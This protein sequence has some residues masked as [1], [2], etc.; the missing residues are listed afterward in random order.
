MSSPT[1]ISALAE[2]LA[3]HADHCFGLM[4]NGNAHLIEHLS[5]RG[6]PYTAMRHEAGTVAA[7][8][9]YHRVSGKLAIAT[10][11]YGAGFSNTATALAEAA[12]ARIPVLVVVGEAPSSGVRPWDIDQEMFAAALGVR[13]YTLAPGG[14]A[15]TV[16]RAVAH[17]TRAS[18][19]AVIAIPY[20]LVTAP[21]DEPAPAIAA[22]PRSAA[23]PQE[24]YDLADPDLLA[25]LLAATLDSEA[26]Q[27]AE[28][29]L[30][31][32]DPTPSTALDQT[33]IAAAAAA[34][35]SAERPLVLAGRGAWASGPGISDELGRLADALG[36]LTATTA[37]ARGIFPRAEYDLGVTGG[38]GQEDAMTILHQADVVLVVGAGLNQFTMRFGELFGEGSTVIRID[39]DPVA[40]PKTLHAIEYSL[41]QAD[42]SAAVRAVTVALAASPRTGPQWRDAVSGLEPGGALRVR[43]DGLGEHPDGLC[44]DGRLDPRAVAARIG[45]LLP[46]TSYITTDGGHFI[47]WSSMFWPVPS[48]ER[49]IMVGTAYQTIGLGFPT[50]AGVS[51]A[52]PEGTVVLSTGDGGGLMAL[53]DLETAIRTAASCAIVVWNDGAYGA[54]VHLYGV[55]GL[56]QQPM[57]IP[58]IDFAGLAEVLGG[59]G[60]RVRSL[61]DL[62]RLADWVREGSTGTI[63]LDCRIS[64]SVVAPYQR[65]IQ[66]VNGL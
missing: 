40:P 38:F 66:R 43:D 39:R 2:E 12:Q 65:E 25:G 44:A 20:D 42:A 31:V 61:A 32:E 17:A 63:V 11:T 28:A 62:D 5:S 13:T 56:S 49:L 35:A 50:V 37:L 7:A 55:M 54:E 26:A 53:A 23:T 52:A 19:P 45:E 58:D 8:D 15:E 6:V 59:T 4:G 60:V 14:I 22:P 24:R 51:A 46:D 27:A 29:G 3:R 33:V 64:R 47:G 30:P 18:R 16:R 36:A 48:P 21:V 57:L 9:A 1:L 41:I 10:T 34:L